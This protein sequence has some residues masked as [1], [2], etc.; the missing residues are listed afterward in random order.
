MALPKYDQTFIPILEVLSNGE[1]IPYNKMKQTVHDRYYLG[2]P[3]EIL[4]QKTKNGDNL[5][6]NRIGW[7]KLYL[8]RGKF[9]QQPRRGFIQITEKY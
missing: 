3:S 1:E 9:V 4:N 7:G 5:L 6:L 2:L 8:K